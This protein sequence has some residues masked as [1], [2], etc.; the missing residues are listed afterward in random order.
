M[1]SDSLAAKVFMTEA[2]QTPDSVSRI[3]NRR[4]SLLSSDKD[5]EQYHWTSKLGGDLKK[6]TILGESA[7]AC[8]CDWISLS[9]FNHKVLH[10]MEIHNLRSF[11]QL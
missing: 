3:S 6:A 11:V 10:S 2:L 8:Y 7:G 4:N 5:D 9:N 1:S